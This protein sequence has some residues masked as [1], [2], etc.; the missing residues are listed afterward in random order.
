M[1]ESEDILSPDEPLTAAELARYE[2]NGVLVLNAVW[3]GLDA[4]RRVASA[5]FYVNIYC[6]IADNTSNGFQNVEE[7]NF[8]K[9]LYCA[10][11]SGTETVPISGTGTSDYLLLA[12]PTSESTAYETDTTLRSMTQQPY[13]GVMFSDFPTDEDVLRSIRASG[14]KIELD[15]VQIPTEQLT[16]EHFKVRWYVLKYNRS[17]GWHVD[18]V[19]VAKEAHL[20][21][22]KTFLGDAQAIAQVT[23]PENDYRIIVS[24]SGTASGAAAE[25][26]ELT[27]RSAAEETRAGCLGYSSFDPETNTYVWLPSGHPNGHYTLRESNYTL[28]GDWHISSD[29]KITNSENATD[30]WQE[31]EDSAVTVRAESYP[32]DMPSSAF[33]TVA[34]R[35][36]YVHSGV[37]T[38]FK[39]DSFSSGGLAGVSFTLRAA[40]RPA[41][42]L[43]LYQ[44][45]GTAE[46]SSDV[47]SEGYTQPVEDGAVT[48]DA[49]GNVYLELPA[50]S[51]TLRETMPTGYTGAAEIE[52]TL[53][54]H[55]EVTKLT[56]RTAQ[57][58]A[59]TDLTGV[60]SGACTARLTVFNQ[61][62]LLTTV[63]AEADWGAT[64]EAQQAEIMVELY[65]NGVKLSG[66]AYTQVLN[67]ANGWS[68]VWENL[69]LFINGEIA[70]FSLK[71]ANRLHGSGGCRRGLYDDRG[72]IPH[73]KYAGHAQAGTR[74][75]SGPEAQSRPGPE[76]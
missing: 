75:R 55:G 74:S 39:M 13:S 36:S 49:N 5:N 37:L 62:H 7:S 43:K 71:E 67:A 65:C 26:Y 53:N 8:T 73:Y 69:P 17:D 6:E 18:G 72:R 60:A 10:A 25:D 56:A 64:P 30:G 47:H 70:Q 11:L 50:G 38:L 46:Y 52:F 28:A 16:T 44:K 3:S 61:S 31:Y 35:N 63:R 58:E 45:P 15:G 22:E 41:E 2:E 19:L 24:H 76:A 34:F 32:S 33:Q 59:L 9:S 51:Y 48:T 66:P 27:L 1:A 12:P 57:G 29:Y 21:V 4:H 40:E 20:R 68:Y 42:V 54:A 14:H 23:A